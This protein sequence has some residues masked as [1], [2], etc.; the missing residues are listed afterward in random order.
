MCEKCDLE[1]S[2]R[3]SLIFKESSVKMNVR[4]SACWFVQI[5]IVLYYKSRLLQKKFFFDR[6][7]PEFFLDI[8]GPGTSFHIVLLAKCFDFFFFCI[9]ANWP[10]FI[11][12][13]GFLPMLCSKM[14]LFHAFPVLQ[15][16]FWIWK[17]T[18]MNVVDTNFKK[19]D[20]I[21][22]TSSDISEKFQK[23]NITWKRKRN[24]TNFNGR[25]TI[26]TFL[27]KFSFN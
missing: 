9:M 21:N 17:I 22:K 11:N 3:P 7:L 10:N 15:G 1:T 18:N 24:I 5:L 8:K 20:I 2:S 4:R 26:Q 12:R 16:L 6:T 14:Y 13:L 19:T 25:F 23:K 27:H